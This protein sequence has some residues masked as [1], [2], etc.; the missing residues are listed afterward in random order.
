[1]ALKVR[2]IVILC[3]VQCWYQCTKPPLLQ[4]L[5]LVRVL[6]TI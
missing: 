6:E 3:P 4:I 2:H 1:M 5:A